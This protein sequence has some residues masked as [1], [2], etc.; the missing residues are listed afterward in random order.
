MSRAVPLAVIVPLA[1][2]VLAMLAPGRMVRAL[3]LAGAVATALTAAGVVLAVSIGGADSYPIGG[4]G[5]PLGI[6]LFFDGLAA[7]MV[8]LT[9]AVGLATA[10]YATSYFQGPTDG[11]RWTEEGR[12]WPSMLLLWTGLNAIYLSADLFNLYVSVEL[13]SIAGVAL[14]IVGRGPGEIRAGLRYLMAAFAGS[15][16]YLLG[17]AILYAETGSLALYGVE[18]APDGAAS[19]ALGLMTAGLLVKT[20]LF[21][22]HFWLPPAHSIAPAPVSALLSGLVVK[23]TFYIVV[24]LWFQALPEVV[25]PGATQLVG[26]LA[27]GAI[28]WGSVQA[29]RQ[30]RL[31]LIVAYSTVAQLGFVF[32]MVPLIG[33][34]G[35]LGPEAEPWAEQAWNGAVYYAV[36]HGLAKAALFF[37]AGT[38][39]HLLG[40]DRIDRLGG[41]A[42]LMPASTLAYGIAGLS[43]IGLPPSGG[44]VS[45]WLLLQASIG[46]GRWWAVALLLGGGLLTASY[47]LRG[48]RVFFA[49]DI[50]TGDV[51]LPLSATH[52]VVALALA[53]AVLGLGVRAIEPLALIEVGAVFEGAEP[54]PGERGT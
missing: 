7:T 40:T 48:A 44:F 46:T 10:V 8:G 23:S 34:V 53:L 22:F 21:P 32:L 16:S 49:A 19:L 26:W 25:T 9:G 17:V 39:L 52:K 27:G 3:G 54:L 29:L 1:F 20:G 31:K 18:V 37:V 38:I 11:R 14:V 4:W 36:S 13:V 35:S 42:G 47:L 45:K 33:P 24:R 5:A 51:R 15:M 50:E 41:L 30:V 2:G 6:D 28:L 43:L 12:F